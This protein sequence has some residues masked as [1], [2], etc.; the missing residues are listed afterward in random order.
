MDHTNELI[1]DERIP[2]RELPARSTAATAEIAT[3]LASIEAK[4]ERLLASQSQ[5]AQAFYSTSDVANL[6]G[7]AEWTVRE[8]CRLGRINA[9]KRETGRGCAKEWM[10]SHDELQRIKSEG[11]LPVDGYRHRVR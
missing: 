2:Q 5:Q 8:W 11:L 1:G 6:L 4:L 10:I 9:E 7:K 3:R